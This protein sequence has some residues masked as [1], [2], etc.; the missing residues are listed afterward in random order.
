MGKSAIRSARDLNPDHFMLSEGKENV[1]CNNAVNK[2]TSGS[3]LARLFERTNIY[4]EAKLKWL[5][6]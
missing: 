4:E 6:H 1:G 5:K 2:E 3:W